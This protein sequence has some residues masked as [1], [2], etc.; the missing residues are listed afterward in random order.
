M[1]FAAGKIS[2]CENPAEPRVWRVPCQWCPTPTIYS[3]FLEQWSVTVKPEFH[4]DADNMDLLVPFEERLQLQST[5][6]AWPKCPEY[7]LLTNNGR[8]FKYEFTFRD[9]FKFN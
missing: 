7:L 4:E 9:T 1:G 2:N 8:T 3:W 6:P 5:N